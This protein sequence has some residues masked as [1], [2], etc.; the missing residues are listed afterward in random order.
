MTAATSFWAT[1]GGW[2]VITLGQ[3]LVVMGVL[4]WRWRS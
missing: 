3:T 1:P 2:T 4:L